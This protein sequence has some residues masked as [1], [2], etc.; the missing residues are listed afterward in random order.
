MANSN[1][2]KYKSKICQSLGVGYTENDRKELSRSL[3]RALAEIKKREYSKIFKDEGIQHLHDF[4]LT[5]K[6]ENLFCKTVGDELRIATAVPDWWF[7]WKKISK[8]E[9]ISEIIDGEFHFL[10]QYIF[11]ASK[12]NIL[13]ALS[14]CEDIGLE[15]FQRS[16]SYT[17][18]SDWKKERESCIEK[19]FDDVEYSESELG[20]S[21]RDIAH[22]INCLDPDI[23]R[24]VYYYIEAKR[25]KNEGFWRSAITDLQSVVDAVVDYM[26]KRKKVSGET[27]WRDTLKYHL[28]V[29][30][31][32]VEQLEN[33]YELRNNFTAHPAHSKWWDFSEIFDDEIENCFDVVEDL[34]LLVFNYENA[35]RIIEKEP[36][37]WSKWYEDNTHIIF[38]TIGFHK[39]PDMHGNGEQL[40]EE[41]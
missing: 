15:F 37:R 31:K 21:V 25:L 20:E 10:V 32:N 22:K 19:F 27:N 16:G 30:I 1:F 9:Y 35:N 3:D 29:E 39:L 12:L 4:D 5:F 17:R 8:L 40:N 14:Y 38:D 23:N 24:I 33:L 41:T 18:H 36:L 13:A 34:L 7:G 28:R 6:A 26:R 11:R 2:N